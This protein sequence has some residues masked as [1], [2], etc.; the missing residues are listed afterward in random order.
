MATYIAISHKNNLI[1]CQADD[2]IK[3][4][5]LAQKLTNWNEPGSIAPYFITTIDWIK[6][7][8]WVTI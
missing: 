1:I 8:K 7:N 6:E 4:S 2:Y 5:D 3:C